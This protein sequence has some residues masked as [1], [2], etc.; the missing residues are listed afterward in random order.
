MVSMSAFLCEELQEYF[1]MIY[2]PDPKERIFPVTKS[3]L[4]REIQRGAKEAGL[5]RIRV[6]DLRHSHVSLLIHMGY[7]PVAIAKR[8]GHKSIDIT[9]RYAHLFPSVQTEMAIQLNEL[10]EGPSDVA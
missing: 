6:H 9:F 5:R 1:D 3:Y 10:K 2:D 8:V 4:N 7:S